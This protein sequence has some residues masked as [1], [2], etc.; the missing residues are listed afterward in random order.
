MEA[1]TADR[2][3]YL[4][5][6][7][8]HLG[9][10]VSTAEAHYARG[11]IHALDGESDLAEAEFQEALSVDPTSD[12]AHQS[13]GVLYFDRDQPERG[14]RHFKEAMALRPLS[15]RIRIKACQL[16]FKHK[17]YPG[18][19]EVGQEILSM[20]GDQATA[21]TLLGWIAQAQSALG[22]L[23]RALETS[24]QAA[25]LSPADASLLN[26]VGVLQLRLG[27]A[28]RAS[29]TLRNALAL[30]ATSQVVRRNLALAEKRQQ[31]AGQPAQ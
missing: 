16:C 11:I 4:T 21:L 25:R 17:Y 19:I 18:V 22:Q 6:F 13:L 1:A 2:Y 3:D 31:P 24:L 8:V 26:N 23:D 20:D 14:Y 9:R 30:D 15:R 5:Q 10:H 29:Q 27:Q 12:S 7:N 28:Q